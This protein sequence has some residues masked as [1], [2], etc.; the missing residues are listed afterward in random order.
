MYHT[1]K[2]MV[3]Q[4]SRRKNSGAPG[5]VLSW[6]DLR[7][8]GAGVKL[9]AEGSPR[10]DRPMPPP[11][12]KD[13]R[14]RISFQFLTWS[15]LSGRIGQDGSGE[16][17]D[18]KRSILPERPRARRRP[19]AVAAGEVRDAGRFSMRWIP[20]VLPGDSERK[21]TGSFRRNL[22]GMEAKRSQE[23][24]GVRTWWRDRKPC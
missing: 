18:Q 16:A 5:G 10:V 24:G 21:K 11:R 1:P 19:G 9:R 20:G 22:G 13:R 14:K 2:G 8:V 12:G 7:S 3:L 4:F 15:F 6:V 23:R 17:K